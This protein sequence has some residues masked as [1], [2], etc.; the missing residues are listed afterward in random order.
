MTNKKINKFI[1]L[2]LTIL[3]FCSQMFGCD[4]GV[5]ARYRSFEMENGGYKTTVVFDTKN[6]IIKDGK[7]D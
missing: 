6:P 1:C 5:G 7:T 3:V 4:D 2:V